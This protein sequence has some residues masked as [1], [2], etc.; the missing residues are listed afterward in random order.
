MAKKTSGTTSRSSSEGNGTLVG[1][2]PPYED[3]AGVDRF[4]FTLLSI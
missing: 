2:L 1:G 3:A 4:G